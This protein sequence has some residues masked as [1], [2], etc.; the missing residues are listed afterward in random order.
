MKINHLLRLKVSQARQVKI[1]VL[2]G[3]RI[4]QKLQLHKILVH[5]RAIRL[6][7]ANLQAQ[8][9]VNLANPKIKQATRAQNTQKPIILRKCRIPLISKIYRRQRVIPQ[10]L[11]S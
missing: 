5:T 7:L 4:I 8:T 10:F 9:Q 6:Q 1:Q 2:C 11:K 3:P